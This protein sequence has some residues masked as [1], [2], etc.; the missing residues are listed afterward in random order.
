MLAGMRVLLVDHTGHVSGAERSLLSLVDGLVA[1]G[2]ECVVACPVD[3]PLAELAAARGVRV[4]AITGTDGSL[5]LHPWR[6]AVAVAELGHAALQVARHARRIGV[7]VIHANSIR[8]SLL[9]GPAGRLVGRPTVGH[10]RDR[11][12][13]GAVATAS[14]RLASRTC[15]VLVANSRHTA[16]G[17]RLAGGGEPVVVANPIDLAVFHPDDAT[18]AGTRRGLGLDDATCAVGVVGQ[19]TPWKGQ[20]MALRAVAAAAD[21]RDVRLL[22]VGEAKFLSAATRYD[23]AAYLDELQRR[24]AA[25]PLAGRVSFLGE[26]DDVPALMRALDLLLVPSW[27]EPFGRVVVEA[28][29]SGTP[30]VATSVGGPAEIVRDGVDGMLVDPRDEDGWARTVTALVDDPGR[31]AALAT[32][33]RGAVDAYDVPAHAAAMLDVYRR[34]IAEGGRPA[35]R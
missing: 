21:G 10:V 4:V 2:V 13:P 32:A 25:P 22:V 1:Q 30:V 19:L 20:E 18:R 26:R 23:N 12:P 35:R 14:L 5:K 24:A 17:V 34:V 3:G 9:V 31:R 7:D 33:A 8:S 29:A 15:T 16:E 27:D 6:T 11:L 28:M